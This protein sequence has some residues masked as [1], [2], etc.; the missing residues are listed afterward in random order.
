MV[1]YPIPGN[2]D[3]VRAIDLYCSLMEEAII[4]GIQQGLASAGVDIGALDKPVAE[5]VSENA[6]ELAS[7][8]ENIA[9][10]T[11]EEQ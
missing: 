10:E 6:S 9:E 11:S 4:D 7:E 1:D 3:S 8:T 5:T 2:D